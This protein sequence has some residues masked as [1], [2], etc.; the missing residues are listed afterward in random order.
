MQ[1]DKWILIGVCKYQLDWAQID[2]LAKRFAK[3]KVLP[4]GYMY[5]ELHAK[6]QIPIA[7]A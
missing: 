3:I 7:L 6:K 5:P 2:K 4:Q 1:L